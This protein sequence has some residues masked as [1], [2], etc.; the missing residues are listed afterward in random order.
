MKSIKDEVSSERRRRT[1]YPSTLPP[2]HHLL[3]LNPQEA[4]SIKDASR[5]EASITIVDEG[6]ETVLTCAE[7]IAKRVVPLRPP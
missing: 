2:C 1:Y 6:G 7:R 3:Q 4:V 5:K